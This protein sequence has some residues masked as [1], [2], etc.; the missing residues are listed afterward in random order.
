MKQN[1]L[2]SSNQVSLY[3][4]KANELRQQNRKDS[5]SEDVPLAVISGSATENNTEKNKAPPPKKKKFE[6]AAKAG[7][8]GIMCFYIYYL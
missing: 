7:T 6:Q 2:K 3:L 8:N 4:F 5:E 1:L